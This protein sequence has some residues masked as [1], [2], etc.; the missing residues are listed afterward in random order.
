[1]YLS[2]TC[3]LIK[4]IKTIIM[5][6]EFINLFA[7]IN[8]QELEKLTKE[9]PETVAVHDHAENAKSHFTAANLW[10]I[11]NMRKE[12]VLRRTLFS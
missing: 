5:R 1:M 12:R 3:Q 2:L 8:A 10:N 7:E 11:H 9:V 6:T 4:T